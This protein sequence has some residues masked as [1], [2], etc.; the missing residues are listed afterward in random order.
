MSSLAR[1]LPSLCSRLKI[2][3]CYGREDRDLANE[4]GQSLTNA[5]HDVFI[6]ANS[7]KVATDFND[8]I[9]N[10]IGRADRFIF[11]AS[12]HSLSAEAYPQTELG[13]AQ[14]RWP[15]PKGAV[16]PV[17]VDATIDPA[18][19]PVYLRAVQVYKPKGNV[20]AD[21]AAEIEASKT[22]RPACLA[23]TL[24]AAAVALAAAAFVSA[25]G[26]TK[27]SYA[28]VA[29]QQV[30]FRPSKKPGPDDSWQA[31]PVALT[32]IPVNY[33]NDGGAPVRIRDETVTLPLGT[34]TVAF[35]WHNEVEMR[36]NCGD[37]WLCTKTSVGE[38][39]VEPQKTLRRETMYL[40]AATAGFTWRE[41]VD[42]ICRSTAD[43]LDVTL[44]AEGR[45]TNVLGLAAATTRATTCH[46]D[47]KAL[48]EGLQKAGCL[49]STERLPLRQSPMCV[50]ARAP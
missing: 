19:L 34:R 15:S 21:L 49:T 17:L 45:S 29:P 8:V 35:K 46:I 26:F 3:I 36:A 24:V 33:S 2:F 50:G 9:R 10:A 16:W 41:F 43:T 48:R 23:C 30:D 20:V 42:A 5:G 31:S 28:L 14:K 27:A 37:D 11:L 1:W 7:L 4:I 47:L 18:T 40:P 6:D 22:V 25:G 39:T 38:S 32:L 12:R 44:T 13:F